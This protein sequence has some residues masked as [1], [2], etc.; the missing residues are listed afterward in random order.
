MGE[1]ARI[2]KR[3]VAR[4][5]FK[6]LPRSALTPPGRG[7]A[8]TNRLTPTGCAT[9]DLPTPPRHPEPD[10]PGVTS[11]ESAPAASE[12]LIPVVS[13]QLNRNRRRHATGHFDAHP[14][15]SPTSH[16]T[17]IRDSFCSGSRPDVTPPLGVRGFTSV[18]RE[19]EKGPPPEQGSHSWV[20]LTISCQ[21]LR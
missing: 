14:T 13:T 15:P 8:P 19:G 21:T 9:T 5:V 16:L 6:Q 7:L 12:W 18:P 11:S 10:G 4:E 2:L 20:G 17:P 1:V 3:Y